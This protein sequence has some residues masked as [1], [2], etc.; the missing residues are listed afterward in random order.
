M[1]GEGVVTA[2]EKDRQ[3]DTEG[4]GQKSR[5]LLPEVQPLRWGQHQWPP[6]SLVFWLTSPHWGCLALFGGHS[7]HLLRGAL[8]NPFHGLEAGT[9]SLL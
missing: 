7:H 5:V 4:G 1:L 6:F 2:A 3:R 9:E 8:G